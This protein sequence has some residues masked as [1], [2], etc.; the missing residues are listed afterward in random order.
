[1]SE[2]TQL[3]KL[4]HQPEGVRLAFVAA[5]SAQEAIARDVCAMLNGEG[6]ILVIGVEDGRPVAKAVTEAEVKKLRAYLCEAIVP[7]SL[8]TL[9]V[10]KE[11][12]GAVVTVDVPGGADR[13][14]VYDG[15]VYIR[16]GGRSVRASAEAM[17]RMVETQ[18]AEVERWERRVST[19]VTVADLE[20]RLIGETV[21]NAQNKRGYS[22]T[23]ARDT[24][25]VLNDLSLARFG[26]L[27]QAADVLFG[28]RVALRHPQTRLRAVC[29]ETDKGGNYR[30]EQ[31]F[32]GPAFLLL[33]QTMAF[34]KRHVSIATEFPAGRLSRESRPQY[35]FNSL[36]EGLVNA[37]V[38][39]DYATFSGGLS[40]SV[41]PGRIEIWNSGRFPSGITVAELRRAT[42]ASIL[43]NPDISLVFY[44]HELMERVGR[45]TF[46][47]VQECRDFGMRPPE[48]SDKGNGVRL[49]FHALSARGPVAVY[50][51]ERQLALMRDFKSGA[52][53]RAKEYLARCGCEISE[54]Q[55]RRDLAGLESA[56]YLER[57]GATTA[58]TYVRTEKP[59]EFGHS[60]MSGHS[61]DMKGSKL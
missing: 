40:V 48:W 41:Y 45:G 36:R 47:I 6:G 54:R 28:K 60:V 46:K 17:R 59:I 50:L 15:A 18:A 19:G 52:V 37:L 49:T 27:T 8:F 31:L 43:V 1:M 10:D 38:H 14:Y 51:N 5:A 24:G 3:D 56:G 33:E 25:A 26:Q 32:E 12:S 44:L 20:E 57:R 21:R 61:V 39:R 29:Y 13:P 35:P 42:H 4:L 11:T 55:V 7:R 34:F 2:T 16:S 23:D 22:F 58:T 30:D 9:T 53:I